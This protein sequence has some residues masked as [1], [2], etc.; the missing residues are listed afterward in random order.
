MKLINTKY[1]ILLG[2][3]ISITLSVSC[4]NPKQHLIKKL[5]KAENL[6]DINLIESILAD[7]VILFTPDLMPINGKAGVVS[8]YNFIFSKHNFEFVKYITDSIYVEQNKH[9]EIGISIMKKIGQPADTNKFKVVFQQYGREYKVTEISFGEDEDIKRELPK[10]LNPTGKYKVGQTTYFY[11]KAKA[12]NNRLLSFQ[13]WYPTQST[14]TKTI[15]QSKEVVEASTNFLGFPLFLVNYFSFIKSNSF[16]NVLAFPNKKFPILLYN[17]GYGGFTSVYQTVFEDL[18]SHGYIVVSIAHEN[19]SALFITAEGNVIPNNPENTFYTSRSPE[20]NGSKINEYQSVILNSDNLNEN[21]KA[22]EKLI[23]LSPLHN[24]ST[25]LWQS[26]TKAVYVKLVELN[27]TDINL[28]GAFDFESVGIF[29]HS[30]GGA[31]AGQLGFEND[32]IKAGINLDGFQFGD[33]I[34][35]RLKIPFMF[36]SGNQEGNRYL[37]ASTFID[38]SEADCYQVAI[39]GFTH[40][41]FTDLEYFLQ[42]NSKMIELQRELIRKFF[43]KYLKNENINLKDIESKYENL[44]L[45]ENNQ[46]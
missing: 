17:H 44:T 4:Q 32:F 2:L 40:S 46:P 37:R 11:E 26:D 6:K 41:S 23:E 30:V 24:E 3:L 25:R 45:N 28:N 42:G 14:N 22:Y 29:G 19:E 21:Q 20:L 18:A 10:L 13:I 16:S 35:N 36:V 38:K 7:N 27:K 33:L 8:I 31:T 1:L 12:N 9:I 39:K 5:E 15:Y 34:N 43:N